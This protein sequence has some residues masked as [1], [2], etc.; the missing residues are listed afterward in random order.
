[1]VAREAREA[2]RSAQFE[3]AGILAARKRE[4]RSRIWSRFRRSIT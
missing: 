2:H 1:M 4:R 3:R